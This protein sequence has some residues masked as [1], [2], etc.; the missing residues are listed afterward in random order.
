MPSF[1]FDCPCA[2]FLLSTFACD[3][4]QQ[5][6]RPSLAAAA[7]LGVGPAGN[8]RKGKRQRKGKRGAL[9]LCTFAFYYSHPCF[10]CLCVAF[11]LL[12][13]TVLPP[14]LLPLRCIAKSKGRR[15][16]QLHTVAK[17]KGEAKSKGCASGKRQ[18]ATSGSVQAHTASSKQGLA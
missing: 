15:A 16:L 2:F 12:G 4:S 14:R 17:S 6:A 9:F 11:C 18:Q 3:Y 13:F 5:Q 7:V 1:A 10:F 8:R